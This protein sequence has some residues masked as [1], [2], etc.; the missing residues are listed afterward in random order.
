MGAIEKIPRPDLPDCC[1]TVLAIRKAGAPM[2]VIAVPNDAANDI[3]INNF[4]AGNFCSRDKSSVIGS[5]TA[6]VVTWWVKAESTAT[7]GMMTA[8]ARLR[9]LPAKC[10]IQSPN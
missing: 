2:I 10:P 3:G 8:I 4:D 1:S 7:D 9:L 5:I 6:V